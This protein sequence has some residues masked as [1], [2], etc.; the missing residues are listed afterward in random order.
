ME[1][2]KA[3]KFRRQ[4]GLTQKAVAEAIG[5]T[6]GCVSQYETGLRGIPVPVAK[7]LAK[8]YG[9]RWS[10]LYEDDDRTA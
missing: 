8:L 9:C 4:N 5:K 1:L 10:D 2:S 6:V 7:K 3:R